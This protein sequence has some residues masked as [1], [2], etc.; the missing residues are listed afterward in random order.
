MRVTQSMY[1]K[2]IY[3]QENS[4]LQSKLF[5]VNKQISSGLKIQYAH[6]DVLTF[7]DTMRL[8]NEI[9]TLGQIKKSTE[10][11]YKMAN[12]TDTLLNEFDTTLTRTR[13]LLLQAS[14]ASQSLDSMDAIASELRGLEGH[15]KNLANTSINGQFIFA[16]SAVSTKPIADDGTYMG[17]SHSMNSFLGAG[18]QQQ[19]N[20][21]GADLF[22]GE[23]S[24]VRRQITTNVPN[25]SLNAKY[26]D[27]SDPSVVGTDV[28]ITTS[29]TIR[30]LMGD[31]DTSGSSPL[32][33]H[34][35]IS[36]SKSN[37]DSFSE[38][39]T[40]S[41]G[42]T[43]DELLTKI[44]SAF[45]NTPSLKL[46][47]VSLSPNGGV[48]VE[49]KMTGS[50]KI[51]FHMTGAVDYTSSR[52]QDDQLQTR[53][54]DTTFVAPIAQEDLVQIGDLTSFDSGDIVEI[55]LTQDGV[56]NTFSYT[57]GVGEDID[58][59]TSGIVSE[60]NTTGVADW[61]AV[62][63]A[64]TTGQFSLE[65]K[66][67]GVPFSSTPPTHDDIDGSGTV[68]GGVTAASVS[69][70]T[71]NNAGT[72]EVT[73]ITV[74]PSAAY[75]IGDIY[76]I[77]IDSIGEVSYVVQA[78]DTATKVAT[79]MALAINESALSSNVTAVDNENGTYTLS[80]VFT[81]ASDPA[82]GLTVTLS[83][84]NVEDINPL[85][86]NIDTAFSPGVGEVNTIT[87]NPRFSFEAGSTYNI[88]IDGIGEVSYTIQ[89]GDTQV[90]VAAGLKLAI[91]GSTLSGEVTVTL[92]TTPDGTFQ[93]TEIVTGGLDVA[94]GLDITLSSDAVL[95]KDSA[96]INDTQYGSFNKGRI[97]NLSNGETNFDAI[98][99][100]YTDVVDQNLYVK[101]FVRSTYEA[102]T[103]LS[104]ELS[105]VSYTMGRTVASGDTLS[106]TMENRDGILSPAYT[107][108]FVTDAATTYNLL[109]ESIEDDGNF[110]VSIVGDTI[111]LA[112][113]TQGM[114]SEIGINSDLA[115]DNGSTLG[116]VNIDS[117]VVNRTVSSDVDELLYDK[118]AF[119]KNG[120]V[121][122]SSIPQV[123]KSTN[124]FASDGTK[125]S[126]VADISKGTLSTV[127]DTLD[128]T[129]F[130]LE[131]LGVNGS[132]YK[133]VID[134]KSSENGGST[135]SVDT[136]GDGVTDA[137]YNI[138][139]VS[140][141]RAAV[142]ADKM[143]YR[144]LMDVVNMVVTG[145][146]PSVAGTH[147]YEDGTPFTEA[148]EYDL[149]VNN[150]Q[151]QGNTY[152]TH[153]GKV[154]F[155][156]ANKTSTK[157]SI[158]LYDSNTGNFDTQSSVMTFNSNN[159]LTIR[160]PKTNF[161]STLNDIIT[162][163]EE[164]KLNVDGTTGIVRN[165][166]MENSTTMMDDL[167]THLGR[168]HSLVGAN[169]NTLNASL[170]RSSLLEISTMTLRSSVIDM[171]LAEASLTLT[172]LSL[173]YEAMLSTVG[174]VSKLSLVNYL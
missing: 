89:D 7:V 162:S 87:I 52:T 151:L 21:S 24:L 135:F 58:S 61:T 124:A 101:N 108:T 2:N 44:G 76:S 90:E 117:T 148:E 60:I 130:K 167:Q 4:Q 23:E 71:A 141:Q 104:N 18:V 29:S 106:I 31:T 26:P 146:N 48:V 133:A 120:S 164:H 5:D 84:V 98:I 80:E 77:N 20:L 132:P 45:G 1:Y 168:S 94:K 129:Q 142:D 147:S 34:F 8:D 49:D 12:Q 63:G 109:K 138:F 33:N 43:V 155:G 79:A 111:S 161:F 56:A 32:T 126:E 123:L 78:G 83:S 93:L 16:G 85:S 172:Q 88:D 99:N 163:I 15:F 145:N 134:F 14:N 121:L 102:S 68:Y 113:T 154:T 25:Y 149:S 122:S 159:A 116:P 96:N 171:D 107:Q 115:N 166:G 70:V 30:D 131:G 47:N 11:G 158:S 95:E 13:T 19:Y 105:S 103:N 160:D 136:T 170:E 36:G 81:S 75:D 9:S 10:S 112:A 100:G 152:L 119:L 173:N 66:N 37:G 6:D 54:I 82:S 62:A 139:D 118:T 3:G 174:K 169:S 156:E 22:L 165:V 97:E 38:H 140:A 92:P 73:T 127:D 144:Q 40:M 65:T 46:V 86:E 150:S 50:S 153:D 74:D 137:T 110:T 17:N 67:T 72:G 35:Y 91:E 41:G 125:I 157:A 42:Q 57:L 53:N 59:V 64:S 28:S 128:G 27:F 69:P 39:I 114:A 51:E 55:T 143:T